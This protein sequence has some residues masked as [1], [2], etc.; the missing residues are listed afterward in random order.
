[1]GK[2]FAEGPVAKDKNDCKELSAFLEFTKKL[3]DLLGPELG[4]QASKCK[5]D[6][7]GLLLTWE[8]SLHAKSLEVAMTFLLDEERDIDQKMEDDELLKT[9][10]DVAPRL[11]SLEMDKETVAKLHECIAV[12]VEIV[13]RQC[14]HGAK[15]GDSMDNPVSLFA[16]ANKLLHY[17][18]ARDPEQQ[19]AR[20]AALEKLNPLLQL[21]SLL[22]NRKTPE[23]L[24]SHPDA[25]QI[26]SNT[27]AATR[28][29]EEAEVT[30][31][32]HLEVLQIARDYLEVVAA[33][34]LKNAHNKIAQAVAKM[35]GCLGMKESSGDINIGKVWW[36]AA[37]KEAT[38]A[39]VVKAAKATILKEDYVKQLNVQYKTLLEAILMRGVVARGQPHCLLRHSLGPEVF[40]HVS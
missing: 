16:S 15:H 33:H 40:K 29:C 38:L 6:A 2:N 36:R 8:H 10:I 28:R 23:E 22:S 5:D 4:P 7:S 13:T 17:L 27:L 9:V 32:V 12:L 35:Q 25:Q 3:V 37:G 1:M 30:E 18:S 31:V 20:E 39:E 21:S 14:K 24:V 11:E 19:P 34:H 26:I